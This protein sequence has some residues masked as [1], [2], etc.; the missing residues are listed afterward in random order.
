MKIV[1]VSLLACFFM[2][3]LV[4]QESKAQEGGVSATVLG[5]TTQPAP[6]GDGKPADDETPVPAPLQPVVDSGATPEVVETEPTDATTEPKPAAP[7]AVESVPEPVVEPKT[8]TSPVVEPP[9]V[10]SEPETPAVVESESASEPAPE[11]EPSIMY[12]YKYDSDREDCSK[13]VLEPWDMQKILEEQNVTV[14]S[15]QKG[16]DGLA[17]SM[18]EWGCRNH[19]PQINIFSIF[20]S[21]YETVKALGFH[22]CEELEERGGSCHPFSYS[23]FDPKTKDKFFVPVYKYSGA[24]FCAPDSGVD[25]NAMEQ[26]LIDVKI[27]VYQKYEAVDGLPHQLFC[28]ED[29]GH[30][31]VYVIEKSG[32]AKSIAMGYRE[33]AWLNMKGGGCYPL[34]E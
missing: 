33:C 25:I 14:L 32:L 31:N 8:E 23:D 13:E 17:Y 21:D 1:L 30:L 9:A 2:F 7:P 28:G 3:P 19:S 18:E 22:A 15:G 26:E 12:V 4:A 6:D 24:E 29:T 5:T 20:V 34:S 10:T 16:Y 27:V 11:P